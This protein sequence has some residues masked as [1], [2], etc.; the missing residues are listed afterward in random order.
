MVS[1]EMRPIHDIN[2]SQ[3]NQELE[4]KWGHFSFLK[5]ILTSTSVTITLGGRGLEVSWRL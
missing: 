5:F 2:N 1:L 4:N 3:L